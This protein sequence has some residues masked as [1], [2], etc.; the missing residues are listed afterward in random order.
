MGIVA[1][2]LFTIAAVCALYVVWQMWWTGVE[3]EH[4]QIEQRQSVGW[5]NPA[6][7]KNQQ[8][9]PA[10]NGA[11]PVQPKQA[12]QGDLIAQIYIPRFGDQWQR[13][14]VE[15]IDMPEL[16]E[17]GIGHY[18]QSQMP[19]QVGNFAVAG[20]RNGYGQPLGNVD[21]LDAKAGDTIIIRTKDYWYVYQYTGYEIVTPDQIRVIAP[22]P[23]SPMSP[24]TQRLITLTTCE[25]K[26]STPTHRW[27]T[28]G[29]LKYWAKVSDGIPQELARQGANGQVQFINNG[30]T[31]PV[32]KISSLIPLILG[33]LM[34][35]LVLFLAAAIVWRWPLRKAICLGEHKK[36]DV[37]IYGGLS[38]LQPGVKP[39]RILLVVLLLAAVALSLFQWVFPWAAQN[40]PLL[41]QMSNYVAINQ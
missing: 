14:I 19:G 11:P 22:N 41:H 15:G 30:K 6:T 36:P 35:Y 16:N 1:E 40:I 20:H 12:R 21:K 10:Q 9:A 18:P 25:P 26:Y 34:V 28:Y 5:S 2:L 38:R 39:V 24:A 8:I 32:A 3:S 37:S 7:E 23:H 27:I 31:S 13:N 29:K 4:T 33:I 17:H